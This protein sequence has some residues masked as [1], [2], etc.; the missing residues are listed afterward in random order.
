MNLWIWEQVEQGTS[1]WS[2]TPFRPYFISPLSSF[3][4]LLSLFVLFNPIWHL[5]VCLNFV[6]DSNS[7]LTFSLNNLF[8]LVFSLEPPLSLHFP[9]KKYFYF[10][11]RL[12]FFPFYSVILFPSLLIFFNEGLIHLFFL[13]YSL[14]SSLRISC[15]FNALSL[16]F[17]SLLQAFLIHSFLLII[18]FV[19]TFSFRLPHTHTSSI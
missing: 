19:S 7:T 9:L 15:Y 14:R 5:S 12:F 1:A 6:L 8:P 3:V 2:L 17:L 18:C 4:T 11:N 10:C 13:T 16:F